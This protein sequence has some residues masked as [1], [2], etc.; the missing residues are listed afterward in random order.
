MKKKSDVKKKPTEDKKSIEKK[1][2]EKEIPKKL[3]KE[4]DKKV[5]KTFSRQYKEKVSQT[6][7]DSI[8]EKI[9]KEIEGLMDQYQNEVNS[10]E[11]GVF[12]ETN[13][14]YRKISRRIIIG[15]GSV[16]LLV[17]LLTILFGVRVAKK[18]ERQIWETHAMQVS[19]LEEYVFKL[20]AKLDSLS[21]RQEE[22]I[23]D[24]V[25]QKLN[26]DA[27][28][29]YTQ[30]L[31]TDQTNKTALPIIQSK[32]NSFIS[33]SEKQFN[34]F[35]DTLEARSSERELSATISQEIKQ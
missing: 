23:N 6:L 20:N 26:S 8:D 32:T 7:S 12:T 29:N 11:E 27:F 33:K 24:Q 25:A 19:Q 1:K 17:I 2:A 16:A 5:D 15:A 31:I 9:G 18:S 4:I 22:L 28:K 13:K 30:G 14:W 21:Q 34:T 35:L 10:F 3:K